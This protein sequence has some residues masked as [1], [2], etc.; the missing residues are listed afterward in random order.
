MK[1]VCVIT[2]GGSGIGLATAKVMGSQGYRILLAGRTAKKLEQAIIE[3]QAMD[4]EAEGFSCDISDRKST[5]QLAAAAFC[6]GNIKV[7]IH[8]AGMSPKMGNALQIM[9]ANALGTININDAFYDVMAEGGCI[10]DT[11]SMSAYMTPKFIMPKGCYKLSRTDRA[12]FMRKMMRRVNLFPASVRVGVS[13]AISK[14]FVI[15]FAKNEAARFG[16]KGI[17]V[18]SITPGNFET[19]MGELEK[20]EAATYMKHNAIKRLGKPEEIAWLYAAVTDERMGYLTGADIICDGGC[21][22][23]GCGPLKRA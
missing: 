7:V 8:A 13:Y 15:W 17:R 23:S 19:P 10:V 2:G 21:V 4:I 12:M 6:R 5:Q 11:S 9:E 20:D 3:L 16:E 1:P 18:L 22:A 14:D